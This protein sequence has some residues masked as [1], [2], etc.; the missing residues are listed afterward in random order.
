MSELIVVSG[1]AG[2]LGRA[3]VTEFRAR[4]CRIA[5]LDLPG[6]GL[7]ALA[8]DQSVHPVPVDLADADAVAKAWSSVDRLG[9]PGALVTVAGGFS[10]GSLDTL[11]PATLD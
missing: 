1:A 6:D 5:A 10:G 3:V 4:N 9:I 7:D 2:A 11:E 8:Q